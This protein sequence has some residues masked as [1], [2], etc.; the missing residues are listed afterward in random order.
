MCRMMKTLHTQLDMET[1]SNDFAIIKIEFV[2]FY[3]TSRIK[4]G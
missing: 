2:N 1:V 4:D 3:G